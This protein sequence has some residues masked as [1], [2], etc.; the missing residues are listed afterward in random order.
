MRVVSIKQSSIS[1]S[2][3][4]VQSSWLHDY[5]TL[6]W[7]SNLRLQLEEVAEQR[8]VD[9]QQAQ[10][11]LELGSR[12]LANAQQQLQFKADIIH[13]LTG[14]LQVSLPPPFPPRSH[15][16]RRTIRQTYY[17]LIIHMS[18]R[19]DRLTFTSVNHVYAVRLCN[20]SLVSSPRFSLTE[21]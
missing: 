6:S 4:H 13:Q 12:Y 9:A 21:R 1:F 7:H 15:G 5:I 14:G 11:E 2:R 10:R 16:R 20:G 18:I 8:S 3:R 17:H 19:C